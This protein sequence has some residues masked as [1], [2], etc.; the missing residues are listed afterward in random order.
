MLK[1]AQERLSAH[2]VTVVVDQEGALAGV[3]KACVSLAC[4]GICVWESYY[5]QVG[6]VPITDAELNACIKGVR[7]LYSRL[8]LGG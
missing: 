5:W 8:P 4:Y 2:A 3:N 6:G 1:H 7:A